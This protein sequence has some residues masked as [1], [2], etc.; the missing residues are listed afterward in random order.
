MAVQRPTLEKAVVRPRGLIL[1]LQIA[2]RIHFK[3]RGP[4]MP[5]QTKRAEHLQ[6]QSA[7][8]PNDHSTLLRQEII[9]RL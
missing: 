7:C 9:E 6:R 3:S 4:G 5:T 1:A 2:I 8:V